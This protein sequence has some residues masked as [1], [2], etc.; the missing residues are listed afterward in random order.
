M[1]NQLSNRSHHLKRDAELLHKIKDTNELN[2]LNLIN[3]INTFQ[4]FHIKIL[5][6]IYQNK[7]WISLNPCD[8]QSMEKE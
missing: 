8:H 5:I 2:M 4:P 7:K 3:I 6:Y 1:S